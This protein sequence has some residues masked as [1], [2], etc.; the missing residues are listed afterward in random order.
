MIITGS[1]IRKLREEAGLSQTDVARLAGISQAHIAK[2]ESEKVDPRLSTVNRILSILV[3]KKKIEIKCREVMKKNVIYAKPDDSIEKI[4][5]VMRKFGISQLPVF[6]ND[7]N[8]GSI[9]ES[10]I[11]KNFG[12]RMKNLQV[13][14]IVDKPFP[15]VDGNDSIEILPSLLDFHPAVLV[16]E[17]GKIKGIITKSDLLNIKG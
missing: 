12:R 4:I 15:V 13:K 5:K 6:Y 9:S 10:T 14:H 11:M 2:I 8:I 16:S 3:T 1:Y 7:A 17:R